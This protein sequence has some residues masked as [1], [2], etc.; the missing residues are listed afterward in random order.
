M[1]PVDA[2]GSPVIVH[3][4]CA[5][6]AYEFWLKAMRR[7]S[8]PVFQ[9]SCPKKVRSQNKASK[10]RTTASTHVGTDLHDTRVKS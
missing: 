3:I 7:T 10:V 9:P 5:Q 1:E 6:D 8:P 2:A 4:D